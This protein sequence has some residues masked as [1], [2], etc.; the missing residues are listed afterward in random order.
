MLNKKTITKAMSCL[1]GSL[2]FT[3]GVHA[4]VVGVV[5]TNE[6]NANAVQV[7]S[8]VTMDS[9]AQGDNVHILSTKGEWFEVMIG[10]KKAMINKDNITYKGA[11][12]KINSGVNFRSNGELDQNNIIT[13]IKEGS[14]IYVLDMDEDFAL[15]SYNDEFGYVYSGK[16]D[17][18]KSDLELIEDIAH[19]TIARVLVDTL[20]VRKDANVSSPIVT[21]VTKGEELEVVSATDQWV[22]ILT[23]D[24]HDAYVAREHIAFDELMNMKKLSGQSTLGEEIAEK[25]MQYLGRPYV[26]GGTSLTNGIDCSAFTQAM[27]RQ[28]GVNISRTSR[29]QIHDGQRVS[30]DSLE[31]GDLVFYGYNNYISHVALYIGNGEIIHASSPKTGV[32]ISS[33]YRGGKPYIGAVRILD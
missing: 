30:I 10:G 5:N 19:K 14:E 27:Y 24:G 32:K 31:A 18:E 16:V 33:V 26:Y 8:T 29:T 12:A 13:H 17:I 21:K 7:S 2:F 25:A 4:Q 6:I 3:V 1:V 28:A 11:K 20:N 22:Q 23:K 15:I 9:I